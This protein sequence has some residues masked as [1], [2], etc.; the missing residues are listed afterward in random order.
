MLS[1]V[2]ALA[3]HQNA[4]ST[5]DAEELY[6]RRVTPTV[7]VAREASPAVVF[8]RNEGRQTIGRDFYGQLM[9]REFSGTG[10]GVVIHKDGFIITNYHVVDGAQKLIVS[11]DDQYDSK[12]YAA[13]VVSSAKEEDLALLKIK[14][15]RDFPTIPLGTSHDLM[16]GEPVIAIGNPYGQTHTVTQG[17]ISG[18]HRNMKIPTQFGNLSFDDLIQTDASINPGN[19]G[20]PLLNINGDLIGINNAMN[21]NAQ[22][23]GFAIPVDHVKKVL[24]ERMLAPDS[25]L[26]WLGFD[27]DGGEH[28]LID[29][30]VP[31]SPA[32]LAG[33]R[34]G[35]CIVA[36][37][38]RPVGSNE[39]YKMARVGLSPAREVEL[40]VER[41]GQAKLVRL[42]P[43]DKYDGTVFEHLGLKVK[44]VETRFRSYIQIVEV[45][46]GGPAAELGL[47]PN[48][49]IDAVRP[50]VGMRP[51]S[52]RIISREMFANLVTE[53]DPGTKL[54]LD[55]YRDVNG[56]GQIT[57]E[58]L[59][60]GSLVIR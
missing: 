52:W 29:R 2:L 1:L 40:R 36:V 38:G 14:G 13:E 54:E 31:G 46:A 8:I 6:R 10:S 37:G 35:D 47:K 32:E 28:L 15:E 44:T 53:L 17:I 24:E 7:L 18:L 57:E 27:V 48:D 25:A 30:I 34:T 51:R 55:V 42:A 9:Q 43:W 41:A 5:E 58:E 23:I 20:G 60:R 59:H 56:D 26:S 16:L 50:T 49:I 4:T 39:E 33:L 19:S 21:S 3:T 45:R 22:N 11:F 12:T